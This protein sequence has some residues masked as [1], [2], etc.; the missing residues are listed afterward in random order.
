VHLISGWLA[1]TRAR[2]R[3]SARFERSLLADFAH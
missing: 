3:F 2:C 1:E